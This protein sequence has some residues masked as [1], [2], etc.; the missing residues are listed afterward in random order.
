VQSARVVGETPAGQGFGGAA[1]ACMMS[2]HFTPALDKSGAV[3]AT[4]L[5]VNVRF[6]R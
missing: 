4:S 1:R 2:K 3:A 6:R 5:R